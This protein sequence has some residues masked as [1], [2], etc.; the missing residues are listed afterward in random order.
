MELGRRSRSRLREATARQLVLQSAPVSRNENGAR[1][2]QR[3]NGRAKNDRGHRGLP[4][5]GR[6]LSLSHRA[7][8]ILY[9]D[10]YLAIA[11]NADPL[12]STN[13]VVARTD[14]ASNC[15]SKENT[16]YWGPGSYVEGDD[17]NYWVATPGSQHD[18]NN[19]NGIVF[20]RSVVPVKDIIDGTSHTL[21][22]AEKYLNP[23]GYLTGYDP[24]DNETIY[25][26]FDN[27][28][29]RTTSTNYPPRRHRRG[30]TD[31]L[32]FG[33]A[34]MQSFN[35]VFCDGGVHS[36][37]FSIDTTMFSCLGGR[38]D[39]QTVPSTLYQ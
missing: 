38:N 24:A 10:P 16:Q 27:D 1:H 4:H 21:L 19:F 17:P 18:P 26:G 36:I 32:A 9:P 30:Y 7:A 12:S 33:S 23:D 6:S 2:G 34:H 20:E 15:G 8:N 25:S 5:H 37:S 3:S 35:A 14:Y 39:R 13:N 29:S 31:W 11:I 28:T 22:F